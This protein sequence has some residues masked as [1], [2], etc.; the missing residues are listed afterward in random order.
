MTFKRLALVLS[1]VLALASFAW[2]KEQLSNESDQQIS[3]FS[4]SGFGEKGKKSWDLSGKSADIFTDVIKLKD[5]TGNLY[6]EKEDIRLTADTGDF[7]KV[8]GKVHLEQN[9]VVTTSSGAKLLTDSLDWDRK[10]QIVTTKDKVNIERENMIT[11]AYGAQGH[12][13][14]NQIKLE[15]DVMVRLNPA[16]ADKNKEDLEKEKTVITCDG[17]LEIDYEKNI[18]VFNNNVKV[19]RGDLLIYSDK[20]DVYFNKDTN[21]QA[22]AGPDGMMGTKVDKIVAHGNV[23]II[24]GD[25]TSYS[26]EAIYTT[27]TK[28]I[29]LLGK[30]RL[31]IYSTED[32]NASFG[33]KGSL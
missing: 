24:R 23:K 13:N 12:P 17:P 2:A 11:T 27:A 4:L 3:D 10:N 30:P 28:K 15:R 9:V 7:D 14:L 8:Q 26:E 21:I 31:V 25:N 33:D 29:T 1:L 16:A 22:Q 18:A 5:I 6:G 20:M 19:D 32:L